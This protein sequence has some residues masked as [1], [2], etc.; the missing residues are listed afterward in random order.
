M[1]DD[2]HA[3]DQID[4]AEAAYRS[5]ELVTQ[6]IIGPL[7][8]RYS[9]EVVD[10]LEPEIQKA[11]YGDKGTTKKSRQTL[12]FGA[13]EITW[14]ARE[15]ERL[16]IGA[17]G[18]ANAAINSAQE[19]KKGVPA[20]HQS[21]A[22]KHLASR[23]IDFRVVRTYGHLGYRRQYHCP[24]AR[25]S[26]IHGTCRG[27]RERLFHRSRRLIRRRAGSRLRFRKPN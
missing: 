13:P 15:A 25:S 27:S 5:R 1:A 26:R 9:D 16:A 11:V 3:L 7:R 19:W 8:N 17:N 14:L 18:D 12:L 2:P 23:R 4:G 22:R 20:E 6:K 24:G 21:N 10:A